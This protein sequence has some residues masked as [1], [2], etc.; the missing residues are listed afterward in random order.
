M[1]DKLREFMD[2]IMD[3]IASFFVS[4]LFLFNN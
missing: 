3:V 2:G 4:I 1:A